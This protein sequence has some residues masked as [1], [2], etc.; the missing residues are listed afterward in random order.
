[1]QLHAGEA[2]PFLTLFVA[3]KG[4]DNA[5]GAPIIEEMKEELSADQYLKQAHAAL[6]LAVAEA[7]KEKDQELQRPD[8]ASAGGGKT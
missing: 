1:M 3:L 6:D 5:E 2:I 4:S 7:V 8:P